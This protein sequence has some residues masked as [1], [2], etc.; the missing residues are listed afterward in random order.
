VH[1]STAI[2]S[3]VRAV[4]A[5]QLPAAMTYGPQAAAAWFVIQTIK[6]IRGR[7]AMNAGG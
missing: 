3:T 7:L 2:L 1:S 4:K 5:M 6:A